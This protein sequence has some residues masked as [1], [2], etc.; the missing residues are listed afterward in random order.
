MFVFLANI[1]S[2]LCGVLFSWPSP[3]IPILISEDY[4]IKIT[5]EE[6]SYLTVIPPICSAIAGIFCS[7]IMN[8]IGR[9]YSYLLVAVPQLSAFIM[10]ACANSI[11]VFYASRVAVGI[12]DGFIY[13]ILP[14]YI[15]EISTPKVRGSWGNTLCFLIY[16]GIL[17]INVVGA[18]CSIKNTAFIFGVFPIL[19]FIAFYFVPESPYYSLIK[20][21]REEAEITLKKLLQ[22][23]N[24]DEEI[25]QL[26]SDVSRQISESG[27]LKDLFIIDSN[28][29]ALIVSIFTRGAQI[30]TGTSAYAVYT[31]YFFEI[32]GSGLSASYSSIVYTG[33]LTGTNFFAACVLDKVGRRMAMILSSLACAIALLSLG[34]YFAIVHF[35]DI[36]LNFIKWFPVFC[37]LVFVIVYS[38]GLG[39]VPTLLLGEI[40][41]A[42][43]KAHAM[44]IINIVFCLYVSTST[45]LFQY[46]TSSFGLYSPFL[47]FGFCCSVSSILS[48]YVVPETKGKTLE[49]I[50]QDL[51]G[52]YKNGVK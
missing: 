36:D 42:S 4:P 3:S 52:N 46:L 9:K 5:L 2:F 34:I 35:T 13:A 23:E 7:R 48:V 16:S 1:P 25:K 27:R 29:K 28:R 40:F 10:I 44:G 20:G 49:Q 18:Y 37:M 26:E 6:A 32:S 51:K 38:L 31:K 39:I 11:Y 8:V 47:F 14:V 41:S 30:Y 50:Q 19:F 12:A 24:V 33:L 45:K 17:L 15:A 22:K 43:I 21:R